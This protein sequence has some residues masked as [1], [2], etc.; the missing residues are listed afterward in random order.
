M[1]ATFRAALEAVRS[2][3]VPVIAALN[4]D[5]LGG[6]AELALACD[7]RIASSHACI[8]FLQ[9]KLAIST[10]WGGGL[11]LLR[12]V[13][14]SRALRYL[15]LAEVMSAQAALE[16]GL[17][18]AVASPTQPF[19]P[20]VEEFCAGFLERTPAVM[21][22]F[23]SLAFA[24]RSGAS[25]AELQRVE[26]EHFATTWIHDDHWRAGEGTLSRVRRT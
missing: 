18:D 5:A 13:G 23:K 3:P 11:D 19:A 2:F 24:Y 4:G 17:I 25:Y 7:I 10:A 16:D 14:V 20:F 1:S 9:G 6:G 21:R 26:T 12:V 22:A 8:G 15:G